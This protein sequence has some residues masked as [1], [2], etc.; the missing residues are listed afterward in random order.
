MDKSRMMMI[1]II[2]L[3]VLLLGVVVGVGVWLIRLPDSDSTNWDMPQP[4]FIE[5]RL[6][7]S[8]LEIFTLE[9]M[10]TNLA[11]GPTGSSDHVLATILVGINTHESVLNTMSESELEEF[12]ADF[13]RKLPIVRSIAI[14]V[15]GASLYED[16]RDNEGRAAAAERIRLNLVDAFNSNL[17]VHVSFS[18]WNLAR[19]SGR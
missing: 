7:P 4:P 13:E 3:L 6:T 8:D 5:H 10:T 14:D 1:V 11:L 19:S 12:I 16:V 2:A 17:I 15:F 9:P 18:D